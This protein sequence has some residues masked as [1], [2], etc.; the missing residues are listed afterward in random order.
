MY[1]HELDNWWNFTYDSNKILSIIGNCFIIV[2]VSS[3]LPNITLCKKKKKERVIKM[4][5]LQVFIL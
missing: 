1:L 2:N 5:N 3:S 4:Y